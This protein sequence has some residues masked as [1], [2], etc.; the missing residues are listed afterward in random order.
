MKSILTFDIG[1]TSLKGAII[2]PQ[3][4]TV[5]LASLSQRPPIPDTGGC[6]EK[7]P[8][9][10]WRDFVR[11][12]GSVLSKP[13]AAGA[14][15]AGV[16]ISGITRTQ[17][18]IDKNGKSIRLAITWADSRARRQADRIIGAMKSI[19]RQARIFGPVNAYH[20]LARLLWLLEEEPQNFEHLHW[21]LEPKDYL[22]FRLT[23]KPAGD[24]I[25]LAR[26]MTIAE[27]ALATELFTQLRLPPEIIPPLLD[28]QQRLGTVRSGLQAPLNQLAG[29]PVFVGGMDAW[30]ACLGLGSLQPNCAY[31]IS[32]TSEVLGVVSESYREIPG[33]ITLPWGQGLYQVGGP[34]QT[35]ADCLLWYLETFGKSNEKADVEATLEKLD[36]LIRQPEPIVF[37]PYLRGERT[38][39]WEPDIR[40]L[41]FGINRRHTSVDFIWAILEG[42]ALAGR[43]IL[44]LATES[45]N[46]KLREVRIGGGAARS[47]L[48]C[49]IRSSVWKQPVV[50]TSAPQA[51]LLG[52]A[53]VGYCGLGDYSSLSQAQSAMVRIDKIIE[54]DHGP[55]DRRSKV[56]D[57]LY[58]HFLKIQTAVLPLSRSF[59]ETINQGLR[60]DA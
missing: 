8:E 22:N 11:I 45:R 28:P 14:Q 55:W 16:V 51:A 44:E 26:L 29:V 38:P 12:A 59:S 20:T 48:W 30:C 1:G 43:Q 15:I 10:L 50:R 39:L 25:S 36:E 23:G 53:M 41:F 52:A 24:K 4:K 60:F 40:G 54:T 27:R 32:G 49:Q 2:D 18:F 7:D 21:V 42:V 56:Y 37:L 9:Q 47:D 5:A 31:N 13:E 6:C 17:I 46:E 3:G 35:G 19:G 33:L 34:T 58:Q 57:L